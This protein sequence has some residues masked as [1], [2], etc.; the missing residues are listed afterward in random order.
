MRTYLEQHGVLLPVIDEEFVSAI[1]VPA[2][3]EVVNM[4]TGRTSITADEMVIDI[5]NA[6][7]TPGVPTPFIW[8]YEPEPNILWIHLSSV[9]PWWFAKRRREGLMVLESAAIKAQ[10]NERSMELSGGP[11][12]Y[13]VDKK[14]HLIDGASKWLY[15]VSLEACVESGMDIPDRLPNNQRI[16]INVPSSFVPEVNVN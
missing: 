7:A 10:M 1:F 12:Q 3:S 2:L 13:L 4:I 9:L 11:G 8:K 6:I 5:V 14:V 16:I 15:G